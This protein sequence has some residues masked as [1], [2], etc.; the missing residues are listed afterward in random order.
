MKNISTV[1]K[2][3]IILKIAIQKLSRKT[4]KIRTSLK[5]PNKFNRQKTE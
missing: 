4:L 5:R 3:N 2:R 1:K